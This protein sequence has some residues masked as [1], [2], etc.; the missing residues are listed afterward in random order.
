MEQ[1]CTIA[2]LIKIFEQIARALGYGRIEHLTIR[3][4]SSETITFS[5]N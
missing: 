1:K 2:E 4:N 5:R 3:Q